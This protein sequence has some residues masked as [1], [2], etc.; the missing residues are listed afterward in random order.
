MLKALLSLLA[1][2]ISMDAKNRNL[3]RSRSPAQKRKNPARK[4]ILAGP[5]GRYYR[6][7]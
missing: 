3:D 2:K 5:S 7:K 6:N 4:L 1:K